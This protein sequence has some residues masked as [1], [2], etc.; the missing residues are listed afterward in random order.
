M[1]NAR[2]AFCT[3]LLA[4]TGQSCPAAACPYMFESEGAVLNFCNIWTGWIQ[5]GP[6]LPRLHF[7]GEVKN[8]SSH[9]WGRVDFI[10]KYS[11]R[12]KTSGKEFS[13]E[14]PIVLDQIISTR[15]IEGSMPV[16]VDR[17][18]V[19]I[20]E[21]V[22]I[23]VNRDY[24]FPKPDDLAA[25][26]LEFNKIQAEEQERQYKLQAEAYNRAVNDFVKSQSLAAKKREQELAI[27]QAAKRKEAEVRLRL[28]QM[29]FSATIHK[30]VVDLTVAEAQSINACR[31]LGLY[32]PSPAVSASPITKVQ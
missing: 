3:C 26:I 15:K 29:I 6:S 24:T 4:L 23:E 28:C 30:K 13:Y 8:L 1:L 11:A 9:V 10:L 5:Q 20:D 18:L 32:V 17:G 25:A 27:R 7:S 22:S 2:I 14:F 12:E 21:K 31:A 19:L 16:G